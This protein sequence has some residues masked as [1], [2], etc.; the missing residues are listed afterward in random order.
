MLDQPP[1]GQLGL[2]AAATRQ[3]DL[4]TREVIPKP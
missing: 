3:N 4:E 1:L 2:P